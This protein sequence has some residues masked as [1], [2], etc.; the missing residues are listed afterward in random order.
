MSEPGVYFIQASQSGLVK[1]GWTSNLTARL[2]ALQVGSAEKLEVLRF[3]RC[4]APDV[5]EGEL[6]RRFAHAR[7][8]G[9]WF[10]ISSSEVDAIEKEG[11]SDVRFE[12]S[13]SALERLA[14]DHVRPLSGRQQ[15]EIGAGRQAVPGRREVFG[16]PHAQPF[17]NVDR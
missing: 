4:E 3:V 14:S 17:F 10:A 16:L 9:E 5:F 13:Q 7:R 12:T 1:I 11:S 2:S 6:H 15:H 8:H